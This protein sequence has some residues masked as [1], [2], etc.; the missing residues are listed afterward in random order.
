M[1]QKNRQVRGQL[2]TLANPPTKVE[3]SDMRACDMKNSDPNGN[4]AGSAAFLIPGM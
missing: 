4:N 3:N 2:V 1:T